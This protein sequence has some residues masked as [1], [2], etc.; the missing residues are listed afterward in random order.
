MRRVPAIRDNRHATAGNFRSSPNLR[1]ALLRVA[2]IG[3]M[4]M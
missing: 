1:V 2:T 3:R 4:A